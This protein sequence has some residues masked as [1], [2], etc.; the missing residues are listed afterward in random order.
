MPIDELIKCR[1]R[2]QIGYQ[3][4]WYDDQVRHSGRISGI[5]PYICA[6]EEVENGHKFTRCLKWID[7]VNKI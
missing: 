7:M 3:V 5:Y 1:N 6:I 2:A 4:S